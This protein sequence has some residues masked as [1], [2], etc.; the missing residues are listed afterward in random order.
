MVL[1]KLQIGKKGLTEEFLQDLKAKF[2]VADNIRVS[3]LPSATRDRIEAKKW[4]T[5]I[6]DSLGPKFRANLIGYTIALRKLRK[7]RVGKFS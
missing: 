3:I 5:T 4:V 7:D 2:E 1:I 6:L